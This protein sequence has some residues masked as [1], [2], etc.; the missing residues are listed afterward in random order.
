MY[1]Q[2][3]LTLPVGAVTSVFGGG[4]LIEAALTVL[5]R[6]AAWGQAAVGPAVSATAS[7]TVPA[8]LAGGRGVGRASLLDAVAWSVSVSFCCRI[9]RTGACRARES[10]PAARAVAG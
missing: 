7:T 8:S 10:K 5:V 6:A 3:S 2:Q 9:V 1:G 4:Q